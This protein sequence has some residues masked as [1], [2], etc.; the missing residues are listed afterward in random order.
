MLGIR[1][2]GHL[3]VNFLSESMYA[4]H[5]L[6]KEVG[7]MGTSGNRDCQLMSR[8]VLK[9][10]TDDASTFSACNVGLPEC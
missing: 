6:W 4:E 9:D 1:G 2:K 3:G 10:F 5:G 7:C 8:S